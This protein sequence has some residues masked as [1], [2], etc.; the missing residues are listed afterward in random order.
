MTGLKFNPV[1]PVI[2]SNTGWCEAAQFSACLKTWRSQLQ[3]GFLQKKAKTF[4]PRN[5]EDT[6]IRRK[7][8]SVTLGGFGEARRINFFLIGCGSFVLGM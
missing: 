6:E 2:L 7:N 4:P 5:T 1:D 8:F 3:A